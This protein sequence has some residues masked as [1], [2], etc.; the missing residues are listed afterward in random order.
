MWWKE[1]AG[2]LSTL[3]HAT[4]K[5]LLYTWRWGTSFLKMYIKHFV[6]TFPPKCLA[7]FPSVTFNQHDSADIN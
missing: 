4:G 5:R 6:K 7:N 2:Q 3:Q 1:K